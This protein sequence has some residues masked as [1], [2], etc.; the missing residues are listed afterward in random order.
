MNDS[1][2]SPLR[3]GSARCSGKRRS[4]TGPPGNTVP[5]SSPLLVGGTS[6]LLESLRT[7]S[8]PTSSSVYSRGSLLKPSSKWAVVKSTMIAMARPKSLEHFIERQTA[9]ADAFAEAMKPIEVVHAHKSIK[10]ETPSRSAERRKCTATRIALDHNAVQHKKLVEN[11]TTRV[12]TQP[13]ALRL[14]WSMA[15]SQKRLDDELR[16]FPDLPLP[17][18]LKNHMNRAEMVQHRLAEQSYRRRIQKSRSRF[19]HEP[20]K[21][22][23]YIRRPMSAMP[24]SRNQQREEVGEHNRYTE[25]YRYSYEGY[26]TRKGSK[27]ALNDSL[28]GKE[29]TCEYKVPILRN[30]TR[31][32]RSRSDSAGQRRPRTGNVRHRHEGATFQQPSIFGF[33]YREE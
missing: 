25:Q 2:E 12:D 17:R 32:S 26:K 24:R 22:F 16:R 5:P 4:V 7:R 8:R 10:V 30:A 19:N 27:N 23:K 1:K 9:R 29:G 6:S 18:A 15:H 31:R 14:Q 11:A 13:P 20:P 33:E 28:F 21:T 3:R